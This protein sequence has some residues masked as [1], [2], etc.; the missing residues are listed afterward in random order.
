MMAKPT[1]LA[2]AANVAWTLNHLTNRAF[3]EALS[4]RDSDAMMQLIKE[5]FCGDEGMH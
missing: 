1:A 3:M 5:Y 2:N 4:V